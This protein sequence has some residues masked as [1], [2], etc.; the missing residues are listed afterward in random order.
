MLA[1]DVSRTTLKTCDTSTFPQKGNR[2]HKR[3][4][5]NKSDKSHKRRKYKSE[6]SD[7]SEEKKGKKVKDKSTKIK[8]T[9]QESE[10]DDEFAA[11]MMIQSSMI[12][13]EFNLKVLLVTMPGMMRTSMTS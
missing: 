3:D 4:R 13:T 6:D 10:S 11:M 2:Q 7:S 5:E 9:K 8:I 1:K 12:P